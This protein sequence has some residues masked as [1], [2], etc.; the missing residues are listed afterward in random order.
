[1]DR[2]LPQKIQDCLDRTYPKRESNYGLWFNRFYDGYSD[3]FRDVP[4]TGKR[5]FLQQMVCSGQCGDSAALKQMLKRQ[6][7]LSH[8]LGGQSAGFECDWHLVTGMGNEHPLENGFTWHP[9]LGTPYLPGSTVK[10]L[11]RAWMEEF[12]DQTEEERQQWFGSRLKKD[13]NPEDNQTGELIFFDAL[14]INEPQLAIDIMTPHMG[15]W[16]EKGD[17]AGQVMN[18]DT[19]PGD[20]H[21]PVP[22]PFLV[23]RN[24]QLMFSVA[25]RPGSS[26][27]MEPVTEALENAL[28]WLGVGSKTAIGYGHMNRKDALLQVLRDAVEQEQQQE[29][30]AAQDAEL[31][32]TQQVI[33]KIERLLASEQVADPSAQ[34]RAQLRELA[35]QDLSDWPQTDKD[36]LWSIAG[37]VFA[38]HGGDKPTSREKKTKIPSL[39]QRLNAAL[40]R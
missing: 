40:G 4:D 12:T 13:G 39:K 29:Q 20:W 33:I 2:P 3:D 38:L 32:E 6:L 21:A 23:S 1:M 22:V 16:Y 10:G 25:P 34:S 5:D 26:L 7:A 18:A 15:K 27:E 14:P 37:Q 9:A 24:T 8:A 35:T 19:L 11:V 30:Q 31:S 28:A 17:D 36:A